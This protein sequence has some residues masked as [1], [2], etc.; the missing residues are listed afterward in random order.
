MLIKRKE[1]SVPELNATSTADISFILLILFLVCS[2]M[3]VDKGLMRQLPLPETQEQQEQVTNV[4]KSKL[5]TLRLTA[6]NQLFV[7]DKLLPV[8]QLQSRLEEFICR[9]GAEHLIS[10]DADRQA[11][12]DA[13][14]QMQNEIVAAYRHVRLKYKDMPMRIAETYNSQVHNT[15]KE[16]VGENLEGGQP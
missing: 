14:F 8:E 10:I 2:S 6:D 15:L 5:M 7:D 11:S 4:E 12:Y 13:Y 1:R 16:G 3:D 9:V